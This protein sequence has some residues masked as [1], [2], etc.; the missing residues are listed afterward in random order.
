MVPY[1]KIAPVKVTR[2]TDIKESLVGGKCSLDVSASV[3]KNNKVAIPAPTAASVKATSTASMVTNKHAEVR[4]N[5]PVMITVENK[6]RILIN[7]NAIMTRKVNNVMSTIATILIL[8][9]Y[10]TMAS[11]LH[12]TL[13]WPGHVLQQVK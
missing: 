2:T 12:V 10:S 7:D 4:L 6:L 11:I 1:I 13:P 9:I 8:L 3:L 5:I